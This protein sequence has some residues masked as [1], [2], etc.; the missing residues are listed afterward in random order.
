M[1]KYLKIRPSPDRSPPDP[2][3]EKTLALIKGPLQS[4]RIP[5]P[6]TEAD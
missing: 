5:V 2:S 3:V 4:T 1:C 6:T